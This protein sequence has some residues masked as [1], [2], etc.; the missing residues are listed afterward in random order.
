MKTVRQILETKRVL[1]SDGAWGTFLARKGLAAGE[2]PERWNIERRDDVLD[3]ARQYIAAGSDMVGTNS[4]GG[5]RFK[6][7]HFGLAGRVGEL[8]EAAAAI[9]REAAGPDRP[10]FASIGPTGKILMMGDVSEEEIYDAFKEQAMALERGGADAACVETM[11][12]IDEAVLALRA[13]KENTALEAI[14]TF[15]FDKVGQDEYRTM[16]GVSPADMAAAVIEAGAA[17]IGSNCGQGGEQ[18]IGIV[19]QLRA[20]APDVPI[21]VQP[22]AGLPVYTDEGT[23]FPETPEVTAGWVPALIE[24][25]ACIVGGCCG[26]TP[27]HIRAIIGVV[28]DVLSKGL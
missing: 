19:R 25:G 3:I 6:L 22:N 10:V 23:V 18:M 20:A 8:N 14:C 1:V 12:A 28:G 9:S 5:T 15:T 4:F 24:A 21:M 27:D 13:V 17:I 2:C 11:T 16:M 7:Q 26:T